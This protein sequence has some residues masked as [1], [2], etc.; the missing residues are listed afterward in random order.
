MGKQHPRKL[1]PRKFMQTE[2]LW[3]GNYGDQENLA[4]RKLN[5][6]NI[7][8][9]KI[10][11][12]F[13]A[14][15]SLVRIMLEICPTHLLNFFLGDYFICVSSPFSQRCNRNGSR[16]E[17]GRRSFRWHLLQI[18]RVDRPKLTVPTECACGEYGK[19]HLRPQMKDVC[20]SCG[21]TESVRMIVYM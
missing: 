14:G 12:F 9:T 7:V 18:A 5:S 2:N 8:S 21:P 11:E 15:T 17:Q 3:H 6:P 19:I 4:L 10:F 20:S 1:S 13:Y 16:N